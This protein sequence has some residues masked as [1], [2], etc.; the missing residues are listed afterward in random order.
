MEE[1]LTQKLAV[2]TIDVDSG[3]VISIEG[4]NGAQVS[5]MAE[6]EL[7]VIH[8]QTGAYNTVAWIVRSHSSPGCV[9][10]IGGSLVK[11]C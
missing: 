9:R 10:L 8:G 6:G 7:K 2:I 1:E 5:E 11:V 3:K 4:R